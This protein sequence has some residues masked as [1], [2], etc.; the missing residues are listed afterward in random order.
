MNSSA[1]LSL[2][3]V[4]LLTIANPAM[5]AEA[6]TVKA[7]TYKSYAELLTGWTPAYAALAAFTT[8]SVY[9]YYSVVGTEDPVHYDMAQLK[10]A[11]A[12]VARNIEVK[13]N[14]QTIGDQL[15]WLYYEGFVGQPSTV[16]S[17]RKNDKTGKVEMPI[18]PARGVMGN[19]HSY[20]KP[21]MKAAVILAVWKSFVTDIQNGVAGWKA[22]MPL[23]TMTAL[24]DGELHKGIVTSTDIKPASK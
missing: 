19:V 3:L 6:P 21:A 20:A 7:P 4:G 8:W 14:I 24:M 18:M 17:P 5:C 1:R 9:S 10:Q 16:G 15:Y 12:N 2:A 11:M 22:I 13:K 23:A